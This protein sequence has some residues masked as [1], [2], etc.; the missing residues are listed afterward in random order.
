MSG[1]T[2][3]V[4]CSPATS[5]R[6]GSVVLSSHVMALVEQLCDTVA[7]MALGYSASGCSRLACGARAQVS[8]SATAATTIAG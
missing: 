2:L 5:H 8:S 3:A 6:F 4:R 7:M 1:T